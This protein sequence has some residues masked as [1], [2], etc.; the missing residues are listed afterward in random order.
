MRRRLGL[1]GMG[2]EEEEGLLVASL[3]N[4]EGKE[5][6]KKGLCVCQRCKSLPQPP[7][8]CLRCEARC[9]SY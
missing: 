7:C 9:C 1:V 3:Q 4:G 6:K 8:V 2:E 5:K